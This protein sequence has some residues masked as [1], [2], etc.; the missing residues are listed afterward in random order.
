MKL[1][2]SL[3]FIALYLLSLVITA[4]ASLIM[5]FI[6]ENLGIKIGSVSG[7]VWKGKLSQVEYQQQPKLQTLSWKFNWL[8]LLKLNLKIDIKFDNGR[9]VLNG[10]GSVN[11]GF[12][13]LRL[14][15]V[16]IDM[17]A[18]ELI[19]YLNL[20]I[21]VTPS[22]KL[23]LTIENGAQGK[24][25]CEALDGYLVWHDAQVET[26]MASID[27]A[28]PSVDLSCL[29]GEL[30]ASLTQDS[31]QL[32]THVNIVLSEGGM[33]QLKGD[34]IGTDK[35]DPTILQALS[36]IGPK[37]ESGETILNFSGRL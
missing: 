1:K 30:V 17:Q 33:Y 36:W 27:L 9:R 16:N 3:A 29:D 32:A 34:I 7:T 22:G 23:T 37:K 20:P 24:P 5:G 28:S 12:S 13:G 8:A 15:G 21:A 35:L 4:P 31:E 19:P 2:L 10:V 14:T 6:P 18:T 25:Y 11:Y 26:P